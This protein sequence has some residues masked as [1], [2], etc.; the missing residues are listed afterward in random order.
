MGW[1]GREFFEPT[2]GSG[3]AIEIALS[4]MLTPDSG[5]GFRSQNLAF[6]YTI[7]RPNHRDAKVLLHMIRMLPI[8]GVRDRIKVQKPQ[9]DSP[10]G[11]NGQL[12]GEICAL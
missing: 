9:E 11:L 2:Y 5:L 8:N 3:S 7:Y 12:E 6:Q 4:N 10:I 1:Q